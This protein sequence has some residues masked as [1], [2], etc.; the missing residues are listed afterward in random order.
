MLWGEV[1]CQSQHKASRVVQR[2]EQTCGCQGQGGMGGG[3]RWESGISRCKV[4]Y[5]GWINNK[6]LLCSTGD[7][8]QYPVIN[9]HGKEY[10]KE[11]IYIYI[12]IYICITESLCCTV[13]INT[14]L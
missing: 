14:T 12:Y 1:K 11:Y 3:M 9:H 7:Y 6:I 10:E 8:I 2:R 13:E 5:I 4:L